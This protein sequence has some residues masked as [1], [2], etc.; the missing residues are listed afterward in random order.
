MAAVVTAVGLFL[1]YLAANQEFV[2]QPE[3]AF[4][5]F[6][7]RLH[8]G[9]IGENGKDPS[10][11]F[12]SPRRQ[13]Y[14]RQ[15]STEVKDFLEWLTTQNGTQASADHYTCRYE[16]QLNN[17]AFYA[18]RNRS[19]LKHAR[20]SKS[21]LTTDRAKIFFRRKSSKSLSGEQKRFPNSRIYDLL[22]EGFV[23]PGGKN[24]P[25][26]EDRF[27]LRDILITILLHGGGLRE[28]EPF[29]LY[30]HDVVAD[31]FDPSIALVRIFHPYEGEAPSDWRDPRRSKSRA[32]RETYLLRKYGMKPRPEY[33]NNLHAGWKN[34]MLEDESGKWMKVHWFPSDWGRL[35]LKLWPL[36]LSQVSRIKSELRNHPFAFISFR[37]SIAGQPYSIAAYE[38]AHQRAVERIGLVSA[39][40]EGTT[41][42]GHR[43]DFGRRMRTAGVDAITRQRALHHSSIESQIPYVQPSAS[44]VSAALEAAERRLN[45]GAKT[46]P[47]ELVRFGFDE[48]DPLGLFSGRQLLGESAQ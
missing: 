6:S 31:P 14:A 46:T 22:F 47:G 16:Q 43:H 33:T 3:E 18:R 24:K 48:V 39:K 23:R 27:S 34:P 2:R 1:D 30:I 19:I 7:E 44:E 12:W 28:S 41:P 45:V 35:F 5:M 20:L 38:L 32:N 8:T 4:S 15:L 37:K 40:S 9:T 25:R 42:H 13:G 10:L 17:L 26:W 21:S 11:L 36:Y 29:H